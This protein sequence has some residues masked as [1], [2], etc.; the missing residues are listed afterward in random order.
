RPIA[1]VYVAEIEKDFAPT[2]QEIEQY[3]K[4]HT[5]RCAVPTRY[6]LARVG[7]VLGRHA[8]PK[9]EEA[10]RERIEAIAA[11]LAAG[12]DFAKVV[13]ETNDMPEKLPGGEL[14]WV[15]EAD[16]VEEFGAPRFADLAVGA[17]T[18]ILRTPRGLEIFKLLDKENART[19][20]LEECRPK[21]TE[22]IR[23][24]FSESVR[25][26]KAD[27]LVE[28]FGA[29]MNMDLFIAAAR[30]AKPLPTPAQ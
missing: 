20:S 8:S 15:N 6:R 29:S 1:D 12:E 19:L 13:A 30:A 28:R 18:E 9:Q 7:V 16:L 17:T 22:T 26:R 25:M 3:Y 14:G 21:L 11:R 5:E 2:D 10:A 4:M 27:E 23:K 24:E